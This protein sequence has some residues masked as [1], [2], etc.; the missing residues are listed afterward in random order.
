MASRGQDLWHKND[1][2][3]LQE[4]VLDLAV[5]GD[6]HAVVKRDLPYDLTIWAQDDDAAAC[7]ELGEPFGPREDIQDRRAIL[8][9]MSSGLLHFPDHRTLKL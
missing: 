2:A 7:G 5:A 9:F 4:E 1:V 8:Q 6:H 3:R